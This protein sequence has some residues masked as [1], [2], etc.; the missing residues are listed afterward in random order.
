MSLVVMTFNLR[1]DV[2]DPGDRAWK[3]RR[4][5][6]AEVFRWHLPDVCGTQE[7]RPNQL[8]DL[9]R[10]LPD[11]QSV[12]EDRRG[13]GKDEACAI[14]FRTDRF[15][16]LEW[17]DFY[18]SESPDAPGS[19]TPAWQNRLPRMATWA[20]LEERGGEKLLVCNVHL[21]HESATARE[22]GTTLILQRLGEMRLVRAEHLP[23]L[24]LG[25]FN[26][27]PGEP[28]R[29]GLANARCGGTTL[30]DVLES[31]PVEDSR[32]RHDFAGEARVAID[33][34]YH[35][36]RLLPREVRIDRERRN[37]VWP[38]D[39]FPVVARFDRVTP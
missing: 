1:L 23:V 38:S 3:V 28:G 31:R 24:V 33:T 27:Q 5:A 37:G 34:I 26:A 2:P 21:D 18:L 25:D 12:G 11:Y 22:R 13:D 15:A 14:F 36:S 35:D 19:I 29:A 39:H 20:V 9:H 32:T 30:Q 7:G 8:L 16:C 17:G 6:V 4:A 10:L